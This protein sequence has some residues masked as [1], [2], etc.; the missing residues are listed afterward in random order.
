MVAIRFEII[1]RLALMSKLSLN[2]ERLSW[3]T[4]KNDAFNLYNNIKEIDWKPESAY[5]WGDSG[6]ENYHPKR[7]MR[8]IERVE[9]E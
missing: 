5:L 6:S 4:S 7:H 2:W 3:K 8:C 1:H 9:E